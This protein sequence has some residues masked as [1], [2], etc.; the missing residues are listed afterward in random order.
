MKVAAATAKEEAAKI[1]LAEAQARE[2]QLKEEALSL[3]PARKLGRY[4]EHRAQSADYRGQLGLVSLARRDFQELSNLFAD[5]EA[6]R[7]RV[8]NLQSASRAKQKQAAELRALQSEK[9][10]AKARQLEDDANRVEQ[11]AQQLNSES[12]RIEE[13]STSIERIVLFVDDLDRCRPEKIVEILQAVHLL[14]AFPLFAV[15]VGVDQRALRQSLQMQLRGLMRQNGRATRQDG[16]GKSRDAYEQ[17][18]TPLDYLEKIFHVP[19]HLPVMGKDAFGQLIEKL[20]GPPITELKV[21]GTVASEDQKSEAVTVLP[22]PVVASTPT[23]VHFASEMPSEVSPEIPVKPLQKELLPPQPIEVTRPMVELDEEELVGSVPLQDWERTALQNYHTLIQTPRGATRL[24]NTYRLV[25]A[26]VPKQEWGLFSSG[27]E[28]KLAMLLL[29]A[30]AGY[31]ATAR[32]W[33]A[34]LSK[35][36]AEALLLEE[37]ADDALPGWNNFKKLYRENVSQ[38]LET[39]FSDVM[40]KW[41]G[42]I[43]KFTF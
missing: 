3:S 35:P 23:V 1:Q 27:G 43:E 42:R 20:T 25:R 17:A 24:L 37:D 22:A 15:V 19:F 9:E 33:F 40:N 8:A 18:A 12:K 31:P 2:N 13:L 16:T 34:D 39:P 28:Y 10:E 7:E 26:G 14:L 38:V 21:T 4:I 41:M 36:G 30:A 6:L 11:E 29:A 32:Q 5:G